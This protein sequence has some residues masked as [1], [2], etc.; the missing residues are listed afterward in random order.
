MS[1]PKRRVRGGSLAPRRGRACPAQRRGDELIGLEHGGANQCRH[2]NPKRREKP[3]RGNGRVDM[4]VAA[5]RGH[6][7]CAGKVVAS[8]RLQRLPRRVVSPPPFKQMRSGSTKRPP[9]HGS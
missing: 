1:G 9:I 8:H 6:D 4:L 3:R 2:G 7:D 5:H